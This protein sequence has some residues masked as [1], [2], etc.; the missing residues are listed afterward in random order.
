ML[1]SVK[2]L[3]TAAERTMAGTMV[4][5]TEEMLVI[6]GWFC[7]S[8]TKLANND[9]KLAV[10][11]QKSLQMTFINLKTGFLTETGFLTRE[12]GFLT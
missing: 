8:V 11:T 7:K 5:I 10:L 1:V 9:L 3:T 4:E 2:E 12:T 6:T